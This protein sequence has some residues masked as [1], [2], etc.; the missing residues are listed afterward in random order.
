MIPGSNLLNQAAR[1]IR[2]TPVPYYKYSARTLNANRQWVSAHEPVVYVPMSVQR[3]P[4]DKYVEFGLE[5]Q[6]NYVSLFASAN[7]LDLTRDTG[8]DQI[9][10]GGRY[11]Q[12]ES[13]N[14]WF[15][16]DGW[17]KSIA[18]QLPANAVAPS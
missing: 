10:W 6:K 1:L 3:V 14:T 9:F 7:L 17:A 8:S 4:R 13:Q 18:V 2:L 12:I 5:L 16:Q 11:Y 15:E